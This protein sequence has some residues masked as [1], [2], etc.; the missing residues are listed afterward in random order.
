MISPEHTRFGQFDVVLA[1]V[2]VVV[3]DD[4]HLIAYCFEFTNE[5]AAI[6]QSNRVKS[7]RKHSNFPFIMSENVPAK[8]S[9]VLYT[10]HSNS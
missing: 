8:I 2:A 9:N 5:S 7:A 3:P 6:D 4:F 10:N 1:V